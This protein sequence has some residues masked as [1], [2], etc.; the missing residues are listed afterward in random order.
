MGVNASSPD[1]A[2]QGSSS[3]L[4]ARVRVSVKERYYE[5]LPQHIN[6]RVALTDEKVRLVAKH[7]NFIA[8]EVRKGYFCVSATGYVCDTEVCIQLVDNPR[9]ATSRT[10]SSRDARN[11]ESPPLCVMY[12]RSEAFLP[13]GRPDVFAQPFH[14]RYF[15]CDF[16]LSERQHPV[17]MRQKSKGARTESAGGRERASTGYT[18]SSFAL[19]VRGDRCVEVHIQLLCAEWKFLQAQN[20]AEKKGHYSPVKRRTPHYCSSEDR[21][22]L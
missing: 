13:A 7:W 1:P 14:S 3:L 17:D 21:E 9:L 16:A 5:Y 19:L 6:R 2:P 8:D 4:G 11:S 15:N 20:E 18:H 12:V 10:V 22:V